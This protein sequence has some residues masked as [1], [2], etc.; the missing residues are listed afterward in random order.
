VEEGEEVLIAGWEPSRS[1]AS[2][3]SVSRGRAAPGRVACPPLAAIPL[4]P[5]IATRPVSSRGS[6]LRSRRTLK[7]LDSWTPSDR[8]ARFGKLGTVA[9]LAPLP[10]PALYSL[11]S[12]MAVPKHSAWLAQR[13]GSDAISAYDLKVLRRSG[14]QTVTFDVNTCVG[15]S[16]ASS[17][18][19]S[20]RRPASAPGL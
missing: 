6:P 4:P 19:S 12:A 14:P 2:L 5:S 8:S 13:K 17:A 16:A 15:R 1:T 7:K 10:S 3:A 9:G 11:T 18:S 20:S